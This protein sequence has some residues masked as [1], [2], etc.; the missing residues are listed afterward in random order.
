MFFVRLF[1]VTDIRWDFEVIR[2]VLLLLSF[3]VF[4]LVLWLFC[5]GLWLSKWVTLLDV[6]V[7]DCEINI[8]TYWDCF[9]E[10]FLVDQ[11]FYQLL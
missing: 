2:M 11:Q 6:L 4:L 1:L 7:D 8:E 10:G 5:I 3:L 9:F